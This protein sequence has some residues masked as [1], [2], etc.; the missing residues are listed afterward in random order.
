M[1]IC[2]DCF[3]HEVCGG[4]IPTDLDEDDVLDFCQNGMADEIP[5]IEELCECFTDKGDLVEV[6]RCK[7]CECFS[8]DY[9]NSVIGSCCSPRQHIRCNENHYCSYG[10]RKTD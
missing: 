8:R 1:S 4:Y 6:V 9:D 2:K 7:D 5:N 10:E 3:H